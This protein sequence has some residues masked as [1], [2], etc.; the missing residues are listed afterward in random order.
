MGTGFHL[1]KVVPLA[2]IDPF[3]DV[4]KALK[5]YAG[6]D[7]PLFVFCGDRN[8]LAIPFVVRLVALAAF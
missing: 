8:A 5:N 3:S 4:S 7:D 1:Q 6:E 2:N